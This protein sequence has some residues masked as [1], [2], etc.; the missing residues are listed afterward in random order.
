MRRK[1]RLEEQATPVRK[2]AAT[3]QQWGLPALGKGV[4]E[5]E[6]LCVRTAWAI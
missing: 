5:A 6:V 1:E 2:W 3:M 4:A